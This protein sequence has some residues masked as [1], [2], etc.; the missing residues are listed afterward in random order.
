[1]D[2]VQRVKNILLQPRAE[3]PIIEA[4]PETTASL[5]TRYLIPLA[6][7]GSVARVIGM[8]VIGVSIPFVGRVRMPIMTSLGSAFIGF[9]AMLVGVYVWALIIN[10]LAPTFGGQKNMLSA[11]K[12]AIYSATPAL[13]ATFLSILPM[14]F[15]LQLLAAIYGLYLLY[16]GFPVMMKVPRERAATYTAATVASGIVLGMI[17]A[18]VSAALGVG[19]GGASRMAGDAGARKASEGILAGVLGAAGGN[20]KESKEAAAGLVAGMVAAGEAAERAEKNGNASGSVSGDSVT[21]AQSGAAMGAAAAALGA[22]ASGGKE[23]VALVDFRLLK[24]LL[25]S[26]AGSATRT[27]ASG[28]K[29]SAGGV[30]G[31]SA[32]GTYSIDGGGSGT[33]KISDMG[34]LRGMIS[35]GKMALSVESESDRGYEKNVTLNG[36]RVHEKWNASGKS[37]ELTAFVGDRFMVEVETSGADVGVAEKLFSSIDVGKLASSK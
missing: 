3:W 26:S 29:T 12:L 13:V 33:V 36:Q 19:M 10:A 7:I 15:L 35:L 21:V 20:T 2:I 34:N 18:G 28:E 5:Y 11:L 22:M 23:Q 6:A 25:P 14:L 4:E 31:S 27:D 37:A 30:S 1:M 24:D 17:F 16:I 8:T 32:R 9:V